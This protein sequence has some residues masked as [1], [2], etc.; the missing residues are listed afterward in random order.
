[1]KKPYISVVALAAVILG[2]VLIVEMSNYLNKYSIND[3][4]AD[5]EK[6]IESRSGMDI[7]IRD[8]VVTDNKLHFVF[9]AGQ[10]VGSGELTRGWNR[11]YKFEFFGHGTNGIRQRIVETD[12]GQYL[13]LAGRNDEY[14][15]SIRAFI[16]GEAYDVTIPDEPYYLVMTPVKRTQLE[17]TSGMIVYDR[18]GRELRRMNLP[19]GSTSPPA[20]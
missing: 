9:T 10:T 14:I 11:K 5:I 2:I 1:M 15:G 3:N 8:R 18:E 4:A 19:A 16:E 7:V 13:M 6:D 12:K 20:P 17:F